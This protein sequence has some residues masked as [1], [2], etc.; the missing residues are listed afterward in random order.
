[1]QELGKLLLPPTAQPGGALT[2][3]V[4]RVSVWTRACNSV[5][6]RIEEWLG[7]AKSELESLD[8]R[9]GALESTNTK[10]A[11]EEELSKAEL[12]Q[13]TL[14]TGGEALQVL[15][16]NTVDDF[17]VGWRTAREVPVGGSP[18]QAVQ[19]LSDVDGE[20]G[21]IDLHPI[22]PGGN[23]LQTLTK[24]ANGSYDLT[25]SEPPR[26]TLFLV[27]T[28]SDLLG[29]NTLSPTFVFG[30]AASSVSAT[31]KVDDGR[32]TLAS[33]V[34]PKG[35]PGLT[36]VS[37]G[38]WVFRHTAR[39]S[40]HTT[41]STFIFYE[42]S[43]ID[44][45]GTESALFR[46][47]STPFA[48]SNSDESA[49][50][51]FLPYVAIDGDDVTTTVKTTTL[52]ESRIVVSVVAYTD[53]PTDVTVE[54]K[55]LEGLG[56]PRVET[57]FLGP[58]WSAVPH[59]GTDGQ[60]LTKKSDS[61]YDVQWEAIPPEAD[62]LGTVTARGATTA[63]ES[64]F[65]DG[66]VTP[67]IRPA[68]NSTT[69]LKINKA[70]G[71][72][73]VVVVDT[74]NTRLG[75]GPYAPSTAFHLSGTAATDVATVDTGLVFSH[76]ARPP[77]F[78]TVLAGAGAGAM[79]VGD[80]Y[81]LVSYSTALGQTNC[82]SNTGGST[83]TGSAGVKVTTTSG[84]GKVNVSVTA[85][86]DY[87]VTAINIYRLDIYLSG[88]ALLVVSLPNVSQTYLDNVADASR[89]GT[90][91][92]YREN[93]TN[94]Q[95]YVDGD[96]ALFAG[97]ANTYFGIGAG[98]NVN[99]EVTGNTFVGN[100]AGVSYTSGSR[101]TLVGFQ[102]G[103]AGA[104]TTDS[105]AVGYFAMRSATGGNNVAVGASALSGNTTGNGN[106]ALGDS[107]L[108]AGV[109]GLSNRLGVGSYAGRYDVS[110]TRCF[111]L[112]TL[113]RS[114]ES[115]GRARAL[116]YGSF[117]SV[118]GS[119]FLTLNASKVHVSDVTTLGS[120]KI[121]NGTF[122][123]DATANWTVPSGSGW[124][125][126]NFR[127]NKT[128]NGTNPLQQ[129]S[130]Q[131]ATPLVVGELY[132][133]SYVLSVWSA[134]SVTPDCGGVTLPA[135]SAANGTYSAMFIPTSTA[136]L[137]FTPSATTARFSIDTVSLKKVSG[138]D[139]TVGGNIR[140]MGTISYPILAAGSTTAGTA[141]IKFTSGSL[142]ASPEAGAVEYVGGYLFIT[143]SALNRR[144][145]VRDDDV[146]SFN[147]EAVFFE[148]SLV[149]L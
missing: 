25:W 97:L 106:T 142:L 39:V 14:P 48:T 52:P 86:T 31:I 62:T 71:A 38:K 41:G 79:G 117:S 33:Y 124:D 140:A 30:G 100:S 12:F 147:D 139:L 91:Q 101:A 59:G 130:A 61:T 36:D 37:A 122:D 115:L 23:M 145:T 107:A 141:P 134:G 9:I 116:M 65:S 78:T 105:V 102:A 4:Q 82:S 70:D 42:V 103:G 21:W 127:V 6:R 69:A 11:A 111:Y 129:T 29:Y 16:K 132:Y 120:E 113:D 81:Y 131:M 56:P 28:A 63:I 137:S 80:H 17:D 32:V 67:E 96:K 109:A 123:T 90:S 10:A 64:T 88:D 73:A 20:V 112:D 46:A 68:A 5:V 83:F 114:T 99:S 121:T 138:G 66:V 26:S 85:S 7:L 98:T 49:N 108:Y 76:V 92:R 95:M 143:D 136:A 119:Q 45:S 84:D 15:S 128:G 104:N 35:F 51:E 144:R 93:T 60:V 89:T 57:P 40:D 110:L 22:P 47:K 72:T 148:D 94:R 118:S 34:S 44:L 75:I 58:H 2:D 146:V 125:G 1:M 13:S 8:S 27:N 126:T 18:G 3:Q 149:I 54:L 43:E 133:L 135:S 19:K 77:A 55:T 74:T 24:A 50:T 87:R 53:S